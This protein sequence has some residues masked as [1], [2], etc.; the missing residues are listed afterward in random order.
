MNQVQGL[1]QNKPKALH[2]NNFYYRP[3]GGEHAAPDYPNSIEKVSCRYAA[4][5]TPSF[6]GT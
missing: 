5:E 1:R 4:A 2:L 3:T 6:A